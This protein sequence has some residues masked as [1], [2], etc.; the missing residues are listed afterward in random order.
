MY[1]NCFSS[2]G[3]NFEK[4]GK[5]VNCTRDLFKGAAGNYDCVKAKS[6]NASKINFKVCTSGRDLMHDTSTSL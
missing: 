6:L 1:Y 3:F 5:F 2:K 4:R